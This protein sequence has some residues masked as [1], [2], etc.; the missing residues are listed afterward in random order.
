MLYLVGAWGVIAMIAAFLLSMRK[1]KN[2]EQKLEESEARFNDT[3]VQ[4][5]H[6]RGKVKMQRKQA[7]RNGFVVGFRSGVGVARGD[8]FVFDDD[9]HSEDDNY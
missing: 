9:H 6:L 5:S 3:Y 8:K 2:T 4:L 7:Y 1:L